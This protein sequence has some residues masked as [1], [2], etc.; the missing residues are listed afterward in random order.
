MGLETAKLD[1][2]K[3]VQ[4]DRFSMS[5]W[6]LCVGLGLLFL[7]YHFHYIWRMGKIAAE[8]PNWSFAFAIPFISIYFMYR[9]KEKLMSLEPRVCLW[10]LIPMMGGMVGYIMA[11]TPVRNDMIQGYCMILSLFGLVLFML[12]PRVMRVTWFSIFYLAVGVKVSQSIWG[13]FAEHMQNYASH[14][15]GFVLGLIGGPLDMEVTQS[16]NSIVLEYNGEKNPLNVAEACAGLR[17][18]MAFVALGFAMAYASAKPIW[19]RLTIASLAVPVAIFVNIMRVV[20]IGLLSTFVNPDAAKGSTHIW[21]GMFMLVPAAGLIWFLGWMMDQIIIHDDD[22]LK[23]TKKKAL[24]I[25]EGWQR[26]AGEDNTG[27]MI[28]CVL[29]CLGLL[30][31][32][33]TVVV[34]HEHIVLGSSI[35]GALGV[36]GLAVGLGRYQVNQFAIFKSMLP[37]IFL[38]FGLLAV[39]LAGIGFGGFLVRF[40]WATKGVLSGTLCGGV[41]LTVVSLIMLGKLKLSASGNLVGSRRVACGV[42]MG[43]FLAGLMGMGGYFDFSDMILFKKQVPM[44]TKYTLMPREKELGDWKFLSEEPPLDSSILEELG[45]TNYFTRSYGYKPRPTDPSWSMGLHVSY[46]TGLADTVPHVPTRCFTAGGA[47]SLGLSVKEMVLSGDQFS[48]SKNFATGFETTTFKGKSVYLPE[49]KIPVTVFTY[50][51]A[52]AMQDQNVVYFFVANGQ[53][54]N[55]PNQVRLKGF[56]PRDEYAF[57]SKVEVRLRD[58]SDPDEAVRRVGEFLSTM[59]PELMACLPDWNEVKAGEWPLDKADKK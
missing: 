51:P 6:T 17:M 47:N 4:S 28:T 11:I 43:V 41:I 25:S 31:Q 16:S 27:L 3:K 55:S 48:K 30:V 14:G 29:G 33:F 19:Q 57:Y 54:L 52:G 34:Y 32:G 15:A 24:S 5:G 1:D 53:F 45:T 10:G 13:A 56:D 49:L 58:V 2:M 23:K 36:L 35:A 37:G 50:R 12:G 9:N 38:A 26:F 7:M 21:I 42:T 39:M 40:E 22:G 18:L 8:D 46:Y 59:L 44:R 20:T